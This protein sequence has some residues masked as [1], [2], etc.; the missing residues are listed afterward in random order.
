MTEQFIR[1]NNNDLNSL[2]NKGNNMFNRLYTVE[3]LLLSLFF[4]Y[5]I[6]IL[7]IYFFNNY[8]ILII[9]LN[10]HFFCALSILKVIKW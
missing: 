10:I 2:I 6:L 5:F 1:I 4:F 8:I 3:Y 7:I 9:I